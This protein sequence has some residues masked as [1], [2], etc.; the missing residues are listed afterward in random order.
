MEEHTLGVY[1][2]THAPQVSLARLS[3]AVGNLYAGL[4]NLKVRTLQDLSY[5]KFVK[6]IKC[7]GGIVNPAVD[8]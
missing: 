4:V 3:L 8:G 7:I 5:L 6:W 1:G 2:V